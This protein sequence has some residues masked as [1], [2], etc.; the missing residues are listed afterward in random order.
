MVPRASPEV[1][2]VFDALDR[3]VVDDVLQRVGVDEEGELLP[4]GPSLE[5]RFWDSSDFAEVAVQVLPVRGQAGVIH[6]AV[7]DVGFEGLTQQR[8]ALVE[9]RG[10]RESE[11]S[12]DQNPGEGPPW[13]YRVRLHRAMRREFKSAPT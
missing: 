8:M 5:V 12:K 13:P 4:L 3:V 10:L 9:S 6:E 2:N 7:L 11:A 1:A